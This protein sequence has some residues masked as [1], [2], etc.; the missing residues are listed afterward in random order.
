MREALRA[1]F[2]HWAARLGEDHLL[3]LRGFG[4]V[5][6]S[7]DEAADELTAADWRAGAPVLR[8]KLE[9]Y[10]PNIAWFH[11]T[12]AINI[13]NT[14]TRAVVGYGSGAAPTRRSAGHSPLTDPSVRPER[15]AGHHHAGPA[16]AVQALVRVKVTWVT[17]RGEEVA[18]TR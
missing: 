11:G 6:E 12:L 16:E 2:P 18:S 7:A 14:D 5:A 3:N 9:H 4:A 13:A 15:H 17:P 10:Q 8:E 1:S